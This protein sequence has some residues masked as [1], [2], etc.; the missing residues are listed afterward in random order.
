MAGGAPRSD[1]SALRLCWVPRACSCGQPWAATRARPRS[2]ACRGLPA[3]AGLRRAG[4][5][6]PAALP[7]RLHTQGRV[8]LPH[9]QVAKQLLHFDG[10]LEDIG[11]K[12]VG[13]YGE[14]LL[15]SFAG[16]FEEALVFY[17]RAVR[18]APNCCRLVR[19]RDK[20][21]VTITRKGTYSLI[22][23]AISLSD[24]PTVAA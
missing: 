13:H 8:P 14:R 6:P 18:Q 21:E 1:G 11:H 22:C 16:R 24:Y 2:T 19:E 5:R 23:V 4:A 3:G 20:C 17:N 15:F 7:P 9:L 10:I 12:D